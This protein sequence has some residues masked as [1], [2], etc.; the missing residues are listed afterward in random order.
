M[1][2]DPE[3]SGVHLAWAAITVLAAGLTAISYGTPI[4][5]S[6]MEEAYRVC[7]PHGG[8]AV[9]EVDGGGLTLATADYEAVCKD[10][11]FVDFQATMKEILIEEGKIRL[12]GRLNDQRR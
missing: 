3:V 6:V 4:S 12:A 8:L 5:T 9:M 10:G 7:V 11:T 1:N 2:T